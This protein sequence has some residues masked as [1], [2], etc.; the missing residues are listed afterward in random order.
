MRKPAIGAVRR[1][2]PRNGPCHDRGTGWSPPEE[3]PLP[4]VTAA[5]GC[6]LHY[7]RT[8][9]GPVVVLI[10]GLGGDGR[11]WTAVM[12][13]LSDRFDLVA[14]DHRG[15]GRS[16]RPAGPYSIGGI[17]R[18]VLAVM[19][20]QGIEAAHLVGHST[21]GAV[22]QTIALDAPHRARSLVISGSWDRPDAR[23]RALFE[24]RA[25]VLD[26]GLAAA[27]QKLT[28]VFG[29]DPAWIEAHAEELERAVAAAA[30]E[31]APLP[32]TAARV[33][34]LLDFDRVAELGRIRQRTL[35][36]AAREDMLIPIHH[37]RRLKALLP[38]ADYAELDGAHF[39][40]R[41]DPVPFAHRVAEF[42]AAPDG[43]VG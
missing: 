36:V 21:G 37:A 5:D 3:G 42:L 19:D 30:A 12:A 35:I 26:A 1:L 27:Y 22:V 25:A 15:A 8:G 9:T 34:M 29:Y 40:P 6:P 10:P 38:H 41:T 20:T 18:D 13:R 24:A 4:T 33:R 28:H 17:A 16:A 2:A 23:F 39:H 14:V 7:E 32:V 11:F 43:S 31:L